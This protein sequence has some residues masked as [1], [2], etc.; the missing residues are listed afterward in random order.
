VQIQLFNSQREY[1][2]ISDE[3]LE[4]AERVLASGHYILGTEVSAFEEEIR[5]YLRAGHALGV[6]SGTDALWLALKA[7]GIGPGDRV[8]TSPFTFFA[9]ASAIM[10]TGAEPVF[11]DVEEDSLN[12]D[13][14]AVRRVLEGNSDHLSRRGIDPGSIKA[15]IPVHLFGQTADMQPLM[16]LAEGFEL[17]VVE[18]VAQALG[19][20]YSGKMAG[21]FGDAGCFSFFPTKNLGGFGDGGLVITD[22]DGLAERIRMLRGHGSE[23]RYLHDTIGTNSRLDAIQAGVLRVK[24]RRISQALEGRRSAAALYREAFVDHP[25]I[26]APSELNE[27]SH[28]YHQYAIRVPAEMRDELRSS[29]ASAGIETAVHYPVPLHLQK[30][31][32]MLGYRPGDF[33]VAEKASNEVISLPMFPSISADECQ[34]VIGAIQKVIPRSRAEVLTESG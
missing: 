16:N 11:A 19:A 28:T 12:V 32:A 5:E 25:L 23:T 2:L 1:G 15:F 18:D 21:T 17:R 4:A 9:T 30:A 27:R 34:Y 20:T 14:E 10:N 13:P 33:P 22:D 31:L 26:R 3:L 29:L 24:L 7:I 8:L 6:G